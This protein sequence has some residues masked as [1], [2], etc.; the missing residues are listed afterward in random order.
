MKF[1][2]KNCGQRYE[3][4]ESDLEY[5][6]NNDINCVSCSKN[7]DMETIFLYKQ[8][9]DKYIADNKKFI[10]FEFE[11]LDLFQQFES[12]C[13]TKII[14]DA[15]KYNSSCKVTSN[16]Y[17][18]LIN[19]LLGIFNSKKKFF[20]RSIHEFI[21]EV[22]ISFYWGRYY[23]SYNLDENESAITF[24][25][26]YESV[27]QK[28]VVEILDIFTK[29]IQ[30]RIKRQKKKSISDDYANVLYNILYNNKCFKEHYEEY[31]KNR[32]LDEFVFQYISG[33]VCYGFWSSRYNHL[34]KPSFVI[35][36]EF[37][38]DK[39][40]TKECIDYLLECGFIK[41]V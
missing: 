14:E 8:N 18:Y 20:D 17:Q 3:V 23:T 19:D 5:Y 22:K 38:C 29:D 40:E 16:V 36:L 15:K 30:N 34:T 26:H 6:K 35:T 9:V 4:E 31:F 27:C 12:Y 24:T 39:F 13:L 25:N 37:L 41:K 10:G 1:A 21:K 2:C 11:L 28:A 33:D 7:I 32:F